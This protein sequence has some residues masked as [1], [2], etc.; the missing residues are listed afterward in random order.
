MF[1]VPYKQKGEEEEGERLMETQE[2]LTPATKKG[3][4]LHSIITIISLSFNV[5][6]VFLGLF[7]LTHKPDATRTASY[8]FG[9][10]SDLGQHANSCFN[11]KS[12]D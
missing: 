1:G 2:P 10:D 11:K 5:F 12:T 8:E 4:Q 6:F 9:F 3:L 7:Y